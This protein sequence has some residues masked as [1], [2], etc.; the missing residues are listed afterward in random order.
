MLYLG[1]LALP[2]LLITYDVLHVTLALDHLLA[3]QLGGVLQHLARQPLLTCYLK[4]KG[5]TRLTNGEFVERL[6]LLLIIEHGTV[7]DALVRG[8][9]L[10]EI[11]VVRRDDAPRP[12]LIKECQKSLRYG[13]TQL[14][15]RACSKLID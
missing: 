15:L 8:C 12:L 4:G 14:R 7:D 6:H 1:A 9:I 2:V 5:A 13:S 11:A 10:L 3:D